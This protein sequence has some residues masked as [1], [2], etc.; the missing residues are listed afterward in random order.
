MSNVEREV[1]QQ[2]HHQILSPWIPTNRI[3]YV[4]SLE[5]GRGRADRRS[6]CQGLLSSEDWGAIHYLYLLSRT[7]GQVR[8]EGHRTHVLSTSRM[9]GF[10]G[11]FVT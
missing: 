3:N 8:E 10:G 2:T 4:G 7:A 6:R 11:S 9:C 1:E 5:I